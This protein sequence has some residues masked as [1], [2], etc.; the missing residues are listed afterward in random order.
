[1]IENDRNSMINIFESILKRVL[2]AVLQFC[3][4]SAH[5]GVALRL[6]STDIPMIFS[7][8]YTI[9][10]WDTNYI[11]IPMA[12]RSMSYYPAYPGI[13]QFPNIPAVFPIQ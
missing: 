2:D 8:S 10:D 12:L 13:F 11:G 5:F 7:D 6:D 3:I 1:M 9:S 4:C